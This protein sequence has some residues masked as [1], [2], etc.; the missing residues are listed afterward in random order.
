MMIIFSYLVA[1]LISV[2]VMVAVAYRFRQHSD[3][4]RTFL[5]M[6]VPVV[7]PVAQQAFSVEALEAPPGWVALMLMI[8]VL[9]TSYFLGSVLNWAV[10]EKKV[11]QTDGKKTDQVDQ[12]AGREVDQVGENKADQNDILWPFYVAFLFWG[13]LYGGSAAGDYLRSEN[14]I[15]F[16]LVFLFGVLIPMLAV[17]GTAGAFSYSNPMRN[18]VVVFITSCSGVIGVVM[19]LSSL[20]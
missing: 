2:I 7:I 9:S 19:Y 14:A 20:A 1:Y 6:V 8:V 16:A 15:I 5:A 12:Q 3:E 11:D 18:K 17:A 10:E 4:P 13:A